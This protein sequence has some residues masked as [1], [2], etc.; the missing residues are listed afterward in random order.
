MIWH[1]FYKDS[2]FLN[3]DVV[4]LVGPSAPLLEALNPLAIALVPIRMT[5]PGPPGYLE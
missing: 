1:H 4:V 3:R 2:G 5:S